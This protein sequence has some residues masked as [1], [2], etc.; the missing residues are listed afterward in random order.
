[1]D[2]ARGHGRVSMRTYSFESSEVVCSTAK[3]MLD[4]SVLNGSRMNVHE[5][6]IYI[7]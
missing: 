3:C 2:F 6:K 1:M 5:W 7:E 4:G